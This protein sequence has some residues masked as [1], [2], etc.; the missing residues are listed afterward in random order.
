VISLQSS[1][2][3]AVCMDFR[4]DQYGFTDTFINFCAPVGRYGP[5]GRLFLKLVCALGGLEPALF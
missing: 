2:G 4:V 3:R 1:V 5:T